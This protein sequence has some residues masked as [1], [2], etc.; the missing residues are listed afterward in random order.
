VWQTDRPS[1]WLVRDGR[2]MAV[3]VVT[4]LDDDAFTEIVSG[5]I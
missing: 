3:A 1:V 2:P 5:D 4:G